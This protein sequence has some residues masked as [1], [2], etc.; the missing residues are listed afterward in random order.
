M[1]G[2]SDVIVEVLK[3]MEPTRVT[4]ASAQILATGLNPSQGIFHLFFRYRA[5]A[6]DF[7]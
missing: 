4:S 1:K 3:E 5:A 2:N 6:R 7:I